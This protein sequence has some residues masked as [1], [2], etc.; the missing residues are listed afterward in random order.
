VERP[1]HEDG[2]AEML[3]VESACLDGTGPDT[4]CRGFTDQVERLGLG[5]P[6]DESD[7]ERTCLDD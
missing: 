2:Q 5:T 1:E 7:D 3:C 4:L 6:E